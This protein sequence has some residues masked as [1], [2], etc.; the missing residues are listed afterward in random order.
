MPSLES[1]ARTQPSAVEPGRLNTRSTRLVVVVATYNRLDLLKRTLASIADGTRGDHEVI[2]A[3]G[4]STDGTIEYLAAQQD[5]TP[6]FQGRLLGTARAYND[7]WR[8][9]ES[10]YTCWLSDDTEVVSGALDE[11]VAILE[12]EPDI[13][14]VGLKMRDTA[15]P[16]QDQPYLGGISAYG[17]LTC[18]HG[19][20]PMALLAAVGGFNEA[21]RSY[22]IDPDLTASVLCAG[23][24][25]VMTRAVSVLHHRRWADEEPWEQRV[26]REMGG[27]DNEAIY[28]RKFRFLAGT[29]TPVA[30]GRRWLMRAAEEALFMGAGPGTSRF[31]GTR[32]DWRNL[33]RG[34]FLPLSFQGR[35]KRPYHLDQ[36]IPARWL[37]HPDN[38]HRVLAA[39]RG[40]AGGGG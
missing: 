22:T 37:A 1:A 15:G 32:R 21:Y 39:S 16:H 14:M 2:V 20:L 25:V 10:R 12:A 27:I 31:G 38:P 24:R 11:A 28:R 9:I 7:V 33:A 6:R 40:E 19:V 13:G 8:R 34:R 3:D 29:A 5:V 26:R 35:A 23:R 17:I 4:G 18:N 36:R 30:W